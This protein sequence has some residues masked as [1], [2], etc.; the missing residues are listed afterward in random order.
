MSS[1]FQFYAPELDCTI[2]LRARST[3]IYQSVF[4]AFFPIVEPQLFFPIICDPKSQ[5]SITASDMHAFCANINGQSN[6]R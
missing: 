5:K 6:K 4:V 2:Y 1:K 3:Q